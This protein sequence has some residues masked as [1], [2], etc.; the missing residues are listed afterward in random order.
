MTP[1]GE[2]AREQARQEKRGGP[3]TLLGPGDT[4]PAD[5]DVARGYIGKKKRKK[6]RQLLGDTRLD[7]D[8]IAS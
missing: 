3:R 8:W 1:L 2:V 6:K 5:S 7:A 4:C